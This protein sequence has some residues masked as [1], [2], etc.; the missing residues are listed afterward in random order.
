MRSI[1]KPFMLCLVVLTGCASPR[2][3]TPPPPVM[4]VVTSTASS[5]A[6]AKDAREK[7]VASASALKTSV[8]VTKT[9]TVRV[10]ERIKT[11]EDP[12]L[13]NEAAALWMEVEELTSLAE[14][15]E[16]RAMDADKAAQRLESDL[17]IVS[18]ERDSAVQSYAQARDLTMLREKE[19]AAN[20]AEA[21]TQ[22]DIERVRADT[23]R[24]RFL[25]L[26]GGVVFTTAIFFLIKS[27]GGLRI[28]I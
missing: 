10:V 4:Q 27:R 16:I 2:K 25:Y 9:A 12:A 20:F 22:K 28:P 11:V 14:L 17:A 18:A 3:V 21:N 6:A 13:R 15:A 19:F 26:L 8:G 23:W 7:A 24:R 5:V 1:F